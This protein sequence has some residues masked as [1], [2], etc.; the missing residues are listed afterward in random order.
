M[1]DVQ[2]VDKLRSKLISYQAT[3]RATHSVYQCK[4]QA[5]E[6]ALFDRSRFEKSVTAIFQGSDTL[7][8]QLQPSL[9]IF[10]G[11]F[12]GIYEASLRSRY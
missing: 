5:F 7:V 10:K 2:P 4:F 9:K 8:Q 12:I 11:R 1:K 6:Y 3:R